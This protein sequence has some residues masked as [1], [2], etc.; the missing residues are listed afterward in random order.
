M[1][2][3]DPESARWFAAEV[4][5]H[6]TSLRS[7]LR[8]KFPAYPDIDDL[9]QETYARLLQAR[10]QGTVATPRAFLFA[11]A[12]NAAFDFFRRRQIA[13]IEGVAEIELLP[14]LE[15]R[16]GVVETVARDQELQMLA[17]AIQALPP[18]C[19]HVLTLRK[20]FGLSHREI[21]AKLEISENTVNAQ[22]AIGVLR[23][24]DY[25]R[26][27]GITDGGAA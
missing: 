11:T 12:R 22:I 25:L 6:E 14:V 20:I 7:Y 27:R 10:E 15:E 5:P 19:R 24:R 16:P 21:A 23:L 1:P 18:R 4:L 3:Q 26:A 17:E 13:S 8:G 2:P 9:V